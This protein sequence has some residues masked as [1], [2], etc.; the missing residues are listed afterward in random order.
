MDSTPFDQEYLAQLVALERHETKPKKGRK[1][2]VEPTHRTPGIS[3]TRTVIEVNHDFIYDLR[4]D[5]TYFVR[6]M[7]MVALD[8]FE[9]RIGRK[10]SVG[11]P[12]IRVLAQRH[13]SET[14]ELL[15]N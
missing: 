2:L 11:I 15:I 3:N 9:E 14:L 4:T 6:L 10:G 1:K 7:S 12:G 5:P 8:E 13:H